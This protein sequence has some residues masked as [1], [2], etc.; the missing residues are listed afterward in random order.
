MGS[1]SI[2]HWLIILITLAPM[3]PIGQVL[4]KA[5]FSPWWA[6]LYMVP[7]FNLVALFV[8]AYSKWPNRA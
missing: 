1:M 4:K 7:I 8:F 2:W 3:F 5:G 6:L